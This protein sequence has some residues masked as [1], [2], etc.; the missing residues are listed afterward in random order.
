MSITGYNY[1]ACYVYAK[2][3]QSCNVT[4]IDWGDGL[5]FTGLGAS[6]SSK[7]WWHAYQP[8]TFTATFTIDVSPYTYTVSFTPDYAADVDV[9]RVTSGGAGKPLNMWNGSTW[10]QVGIVNAVTSHF[11]IKTDAGWDNVHPMSTPAPFKVW[12][13]SS[14]ITVP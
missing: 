8:G 1:S 12:D 14:W 11:Q 5:T 13:G 6:T 4:A 2:I 9:V 3:S 7:Y 10:I